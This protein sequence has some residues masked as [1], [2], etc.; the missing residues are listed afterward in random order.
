MKLNDKRITNGWCMYDWA[1][2]VYSLT[3]TTAIF[4]IY[5]ESVTTQE[6]GSTLVNFLGFSLPNTVL[7]SYAL[8]FSFLFT[9]LIL[10]ILTGI[11]DYGGKKKTFLKIFV[12]VGGLACA[13]MYFFT[14]ENVSFGILMAIIASIGYSGSLVFYDAYLPEIATPDRFDKL[15]ARGYAMGYLGSVIL[16]VINL[17]MIEQP[18][19]FGL[20]DGSIPARISFVTVAIWWIGFAQIPFRRL[21]ENP[22]QHK[23]SGQLFKKGY[24]ELKLV[25]RQISE[26]KHMKRFVIAFFFYNAGVQAVMYLASL[27]GAK[28]LQMESSM[29]ILT[30]LIIQ[31]VAIIG[32][33]LFASISKRKGNVFSLLTMICI[34]ILVCVAAF[35]VQNDLQFFALAFVVGMIMGGIQALSRAT[36]SKLIPVDTEDHA[37]FFSFYDVTFNV[38]IV[39]GTIAYGTIEYIT[40]SMR[41]SALGLGVLF[42]L[43][44]LILKS[45]KVIEARP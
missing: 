6:D 15:S 44:L 34:W 13:G 30:V 14:G 19:L 2:S 3:I 5:Y 20:P 23:V 12:Y 22:Y 38:S 45:V 27:F 40:G 37:S 42:L 10:P 17:V 11:A 28:E 31:L 35:F 25:Y 36:F 24:Q 9:A 16:L 39:L 29:L 26:L 41:F 21:P 43:G 8:S 18:A 4:P 32:A 33:F 1:N 7:Y